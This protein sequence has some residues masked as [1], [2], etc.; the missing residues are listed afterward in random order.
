M[1]CGADGMSTRPFHRVS[2]DG[3]RTLK[4][5][6]D[7][8]GV[9]GTATDSDGVDDMADGVDDMAKSGLL[10]RANHIAFVPN[11]VKALQVADGAGAMGRWEGLWGVVAAGRLE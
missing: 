5:A 6:T 9:D 8:D 10:M 4:V 2:A 7:S 3:T 1:N 11:E